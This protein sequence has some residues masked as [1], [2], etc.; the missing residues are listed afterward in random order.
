MPESFPTQQLAGP[1]VGSKKTA[2][3]PNLFFSV[4]QLAVPE[5]CRH[6]PAFQPHQSWQNT[7]EDRFEDQVYKV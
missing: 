4:L 6:S 3:T 5:K 1:Q 2:K 7:S